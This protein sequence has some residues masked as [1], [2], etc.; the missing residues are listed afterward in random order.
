MTGTGFGQ[1]VSALSSQSLGNSGRDSFDHD[2][3]KLL[4][5]LYFPEQMFFPILTTKRGVISSTLLSV[6]EFIPYS[7]IWSKGAGY[8]PLQ[9]KQENEHEASKAG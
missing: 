8:T 5:L 7:L 6:K 1:N 9:Q 4:I 3:I 2:V